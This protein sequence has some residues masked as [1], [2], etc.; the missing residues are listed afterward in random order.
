[1]DDPEGGVV[2]EL[3]GHIMID[4]I[5]IINGHILD[6]P[7]VPR[8]RGT[9]DGDRSGAVGGRILVPKG[10][11]RLVRCKNIDI[12]DHHI[13]LTGSKGLIHVDFEGFSCRV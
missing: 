10:R 7:S 4:S 6:C 1:M 3:D 13:Q 9:Q 5:L 2:I 8:S 11:N 12:T